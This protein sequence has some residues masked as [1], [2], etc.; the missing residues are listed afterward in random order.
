LRAADLFDDFAARH[1]R[2]ERPDVREYLERAEDDADELAALIDAYLRAVPPR[3]PAPE[4]VA[5]MHALVDGEAPLHR[6]RVARRLTREAV[7]EAL[8]KG[9]KLDFKK[10]S[11]VSRYY[12]RLETGLLDPARVDKR[13][14]AVL[15]RA[16]GAQASDLVASRPA[17]QAA[18]P[19]YFR[20]EPASLPGMD[21][22]ALD[23]AV[24]EE[25]EVDRLF[26][27]SK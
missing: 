2:G 3:E 19:A 5:L 6:L 11:K 27:T 22:A 8:V 17:R 1:A 10:T 18:S 9:L 20:A 24:S 7:V 16:L 12:H 15:A 26:D 13:V 25:D 4:T 21:F 14:F 23:E